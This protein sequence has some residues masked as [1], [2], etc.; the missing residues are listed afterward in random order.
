MAPRRRLR[1]ASAQA[2]LKDDVG[3]GRRKLQSLAQ[4]VRGLEL[5][6]APRS[7]ATAW[8]LR[9]AG[10]GW[11]AIS[12]RRSPRLR[13]GVRSSASHHLQETGRAGLATSFGILPNVSRAAWKSRLRFPAAPGQRAAWCRERDSGGA[14]QPLLRG[15]IAAARP[16]RSLHC[17]KSG[18]GKAPGRLPGQARLGRGGEAR[19]QPADPPGAGPPPPD[20]RPRRARSGCPARRP[21]ADGERQL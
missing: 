8:L 13:G 4:H 5:T 17:G 12:E 10:L 11:S 20:P 21:G 3:G 6:G 16:C 2:R 18:E 1:R 15:Q 9:A 14:D 19:S 7:N